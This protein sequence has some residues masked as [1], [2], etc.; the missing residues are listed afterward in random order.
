MNNNSQFIENSEIYVNRNKEL[1]DYEYLLE[2]LKEIK[3]KIILL[4]NNF[5]LK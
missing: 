3:K 2:R 5:S 4:E 1:N